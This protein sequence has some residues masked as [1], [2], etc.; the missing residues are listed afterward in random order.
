M[1]ENLTLAVPLLSMLVVATIIDCR[2]RRI[3]NGLSLGGAAVGLAAQVAL[4]GL[5]GLA[6]GLLGWIIC[7]AVFLPFYARGGMGAGDVKLIAAVGAFLGPVHGL[8]AALVALLAG[9]L[10]AVVLLTWQ[11]LFST[12]QPDPLPQAAHGAASGDHG[13]LDGYGQPPV[14]G[15]DRKF[16]YAGAIALGTAVVALKP[17]LSSLF[18]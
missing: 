11:W 3:P 16:P 18:A 9:A 6:L 10:I 7:L 14:I 13:D 1:T 8:Q 17:L 12:F 4:G 15:L 5:S 2:R